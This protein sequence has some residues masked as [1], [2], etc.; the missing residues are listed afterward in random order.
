MKGSLQSR[1]KKYSTLVFDCDGVILD[2]N[3]IKTEAFRKVAERFGS[4]AAEQLVQYHVHNGGISRYYKFKF[5]LVN[6]LGRNATQSLI[7]KLASDYGDYVYNG[8]LTCSVTPGLKELRTETKDSKW[9]IVSGGDQDELRRVF[10]SRELDTLFDSGIYGS[11]RTKDKI[12]DTMR[13]E[14]SLKQPALFLGDSR[15]DHQASLNAG[16]EFIFIHGWTE[17]PEWKKYCNVHGL[18]SVDYV[19]NIAEV[20]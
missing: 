3:K 12:L 2:S 20:L 9:M 19:K 15:Y 5:L 11:P 17:L 8:L 16:I 10:A 1:Y 4:Q 14:G 13:F 7:N 6:I 18:R